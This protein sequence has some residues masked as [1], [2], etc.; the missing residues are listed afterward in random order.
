MQVGGSQESLEPV[1]GILAILE[2][3]FEVKR[4]KGCLKLREIRE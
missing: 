2:L 1:V 3:P 4:P